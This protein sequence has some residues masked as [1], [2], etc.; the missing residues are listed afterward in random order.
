[1]VPGPTPDD[2]GWFEGVPAVEVRIDGVWSALGGVTV[3]PAYPGDASAADQAEY[4]FTFEP[5]AVDGVRIA[6]TPGGSGCYTT[7]AELEVLSAG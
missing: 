3:S 2:G 7:I 6:G 4:R 1:M 5:V